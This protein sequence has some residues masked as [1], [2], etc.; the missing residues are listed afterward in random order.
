MRLGALSVLALALCAGPVF[1][2]KVYIDYD[3]DYDGSGVKTFAWKPTSETSIRH[4]NPLLHSRI[5]NGIEYYLSLGGAREQESDPDIYVTYHTSTQQEISVNTAHWGYGYPRSWTYG[6]YGRYGYPYGGAST[7][8]VSKYQKGTL[9][10]D[11][12]DAKSNKLHGLNASGRSPM[13]L[14]L[15]HFVNE[16]LTEVPNFGPLPVTRWTR[17]RLRRPSAPKSPD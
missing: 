11:A 13:G 15:Q 7:T 16:Q 6:G 12:W 3:P 10:V 17:L 9:V 5:V 8:T 14:T 2:Q 4:T 1:A